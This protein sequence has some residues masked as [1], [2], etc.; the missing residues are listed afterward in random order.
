MHLSRINP[1]FASFLSTPNYTLPSYP[2]DT[3]DNPPMSCKVEH[4]DKVVDYSGESFPLDTYY[5]F[6]LLLT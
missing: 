1:A 3:I 5:C 6:D 2:P 4:Q